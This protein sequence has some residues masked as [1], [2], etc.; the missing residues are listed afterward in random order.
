MTEQ[1]NYHLAAVDRRLEAHGQELDTVEKCLERLT[2]LCEQQSKT[3]ADHEVRL[4]EIE[5]RSGAIW[6]K[7]VMALVGALCGG[8]AA[9]ILAAA[10]LQG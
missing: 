3:Q 5:G 1:D 4:R 2:V 6:D 9:Y 8:L 7:A 10:G